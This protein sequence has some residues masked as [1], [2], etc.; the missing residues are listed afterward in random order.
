MYKNIKTLI[1][2][3]AKITFSTEENQEEL[4]ISLESPIKYTDKFFVKKMFIHA[5]SE[6]RPLKQYMVETYKNNVV[7]KCG[8]DVLLK[9]Y[10]PNKVKYLINKDIEKTSFF[11]IEYRKHIRSDYDVSNHVTVKLTYIPEEHES[12]LETAH[13]Y[14]NKFSRGKAN[15]PILVVHFDFTT[16]ELHYAIIKDNIVVESGVIK[17]PPQIW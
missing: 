6:N 7:I 8:S 5:I 13:G 14:V 16:E 11:S 1:I 17:Q 10:V 15:M 3:P 12:M 4:T 2:K 9:I